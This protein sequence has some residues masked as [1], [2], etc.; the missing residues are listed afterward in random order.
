MITKRIT[1][2]RE[3]T[4][5]NLFKLK[6]HNYNKNSYSSA[7]STLDINTLNND[8][9]PTA[10][11]SNRK[12]PTTLDTSESFF[13]DC[14]K[15]DTGVQSTVNRGS[16]YKPDTPPQYGTPILTYV[17]GKLNTAAI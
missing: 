17:N 1:K 5:N 4:K 8:D 6:K 13:S 3:K 2:K 9:N 7:G 11:N 12:Q 16:T 15:R 14:E 10:F